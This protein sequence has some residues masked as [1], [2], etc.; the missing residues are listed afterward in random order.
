M[1]RENCVICMINF[2]IIISMWIYFVVI[3]CIQG[4]KYIIIKRVFNFGV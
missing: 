2:I 1:N 4:Q 3:I